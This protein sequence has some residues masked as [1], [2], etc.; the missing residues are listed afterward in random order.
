MSI[1]VPQVI[2]G[3][4]SSAGTRVAFKSASSPF[5]LA[6]ITALAGNVGTLYLGDKTVSSSVYG[7][8]LT[9][10]QSLAIGSSG[11]DPTFDFKDLYADTS[12][13]GDG[14]SVLFY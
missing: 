6:I 1:Y 7:A 5:R 4:V 2:N 11:N 10:G 3:T 13:S 14:F 8:A 12:S 9:K